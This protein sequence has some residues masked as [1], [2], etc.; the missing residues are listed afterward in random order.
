[1]L[2]GKI[3]ARN[4]CHSVSSWNAL[5]LALLV[6]GVRADDAHHSPAPDDL[7]LV[8]DFLD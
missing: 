7:A 1:M 8:A 5:P 4:T 3:H 6:L 2:I